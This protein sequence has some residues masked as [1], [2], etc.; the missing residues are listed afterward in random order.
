[1]KRTGPSDKKLLE[2]LYDRAGHAMNDP[3]PD[4]ERMFGRMAAEYFGES[5]HQNMPGYEDYRSRRTALRV[6][7]DFERSCQE[8]ESWPE[9]EQ[10]TER[11][12]ILRDE[13]CAE[14][15]R[16]AC[17]P[18]LAYDPRQMALNEAVRGAIDIDAM[19]AYMTPELRREFGLEAEL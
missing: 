12:Q 17:D 18:A 9:D 16:T 15:V 11:M 5:M 14:M 7:A 13:V 3:D 2:N 10:E 19:I 8:V 1:M 6:F 4:A